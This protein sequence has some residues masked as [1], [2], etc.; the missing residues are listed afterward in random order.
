MTDSTVEAR[1]NRLESL[2]ASAGDL[3]LKTSEVAQQNTQQITILERTVTQLT[4]Q[5]INDRAEF[6]EFRRT[7][8]ST[9]A[10]TQAAL[11]KIDRVLDYLMGQNDSPSDP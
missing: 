2:F 11:D 10:S 4:Q 3:M 9:L 6:A 5:A 7:T 8:Q 1:L